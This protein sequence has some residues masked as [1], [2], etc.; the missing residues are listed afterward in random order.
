MIIKRIQASAPLGFAKTASH[1]YSLTAVVRWVF[2]SGFLL[3]KIMESCLEKRERSD[4][5]GAE[6]DV[7]VR[8]GHKLGRG[9]HSGREV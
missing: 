6:H 1:M 8:R 2:L 7:K 4:G 3:L 9:R 5:Q